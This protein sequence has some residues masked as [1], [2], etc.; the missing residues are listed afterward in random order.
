MTRWT[1][2]VRSRPT[3]LPSV[4]E[5][6]VPHP[7]Q[8]HPRVRLSRWTRVAATALAWLQRHP[9][10]SVICRDRS[11]GY[12]EGARQG[13]PQAVQVADR[14]HLWQNLGQAVEKTVNAHRSRLAA[15]AIPPADDAM[16]AQ[17]QPLPE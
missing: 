5:A 15:P 12:A 7:Q 8:L 14:F 2:T 10:V 6:A 4:R 16:P 17:V 9:E 11:G 1:A 3:V 13:A